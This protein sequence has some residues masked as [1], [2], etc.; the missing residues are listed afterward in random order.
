MRLR[1]D[2]R[3]VFTGADHPADRGAPSV[4]PAEP[5]IQGD[6]EGCS[7][8]RKDRQG[9]FPPFRHPGPA[10]DS[11]RPVPHP[12]RIQGT[13]D[14][15]CPECHEMIGD[16]GRLHAPVPRQ[17][18]SG[19]DVDPGLRNMGCERMAEGVTR[20]RFAD[21]G[22]VRCFLNRTHASP[23]GGDAG[24]RAALVAQQALRGQRPDVASITP[25]A[26]DHRALSRHNP[27]SRQPCPQTREPSHRPPSAD[28]PGCFSRNLP[29]PRGT[30]T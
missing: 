23:P 12:R 7:P 18:L 3:G 4:I 30:R 6:A 25:E 14:T 10:R 15:V 1:L 17:F 27:P 2:R 9:S 21:A 16:P 22:L 28:S 20:R 26:A 13:L 24:G 5:G 11:E 19:T 29:S 8:R